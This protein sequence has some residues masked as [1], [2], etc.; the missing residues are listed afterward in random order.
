MQP[1]PPIPADGHLL[2]LSRQGNQEAFR[3]LVERYQTLVCSVAYSQCGSFA[4]SEELAQEAFFAAWKSLADIRDDSK[5]S[6]WLCA[7]TRNIANRATKRERRHSQAMDLR[8]EVAVDPPASTASPVAQAISAE[9]SQLVWNALE[10]MPETYREPLIL[11]Y[12]EEQSVAHVAEALELSP[13]TVKQRLKRGRKMLQGELA[14]TVERALRNS[15]PSGT[16]TVAVMAG[17]S[18]ALA[19][20]ATAAGLSTLAKTTST[21]LAKT[22]TGGLLGL[23]ILPLLV[24]LPVVRWL[25]KTSY[26]EARSER[27]RQLLNQFYA[28]QFVI[29]CVFTIAAFSSIWWGKYLPI[30]DFARGMIPPSLLVPVMV[31]IVVHS[32]RL[33]K[34]IARLRDEEGTATPPRP[35]S[36]ATSSTTARKNVYLLF[37][38][39]GLLVIAWPAILAIRASDWPILAGILALSFAISSAAFGLS[40]RLP[41]YEYQCFGICLPFIVLIGMGVTHWRQEM[42]I[43]GIEGVPWFL[44]NIVGMSTTCVILITLVWKKVYGRSDGRER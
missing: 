4:L 1:T 22:G 42:W 7:I 32:R 15:R 36:V 9:E 20:T 5:F 38:V 44:G 16:F 35:L 24:Q 29:L 37:V 27:E 41:K 12:R 14:G 17:L 43:P 18:G 3:Q 6:S 11:F 34:K 10:G 28:I 21:G 13:D 33:G 23:I 25:Y 8:D 26:Q 19:S 31:L 30:S 40:L 2:D 39:S